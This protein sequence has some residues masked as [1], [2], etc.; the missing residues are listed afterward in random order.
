MADV[1]TSADKSRLDPSIDSIDWFGSEDDFFPPLPAKKDEVCTGDR[2][3]TRPTKDGDSRSGGVQNFDGPESEAVAQ[4][5][6]GQGSRKAGGGTDV[7]PQDGAAGGTDAVRPPDVVQKPALKDNPTFSGEQAAEALK[8]AKD[9]KLPVIVYM[10]ADWCPGCRQLKPQI[11]EKMAQMGGRAVLIAVNADKGIPAELRQTLEG[12]RTIPATWVGEATD[13][14]GFQGSKLGN[15][16]EVLT[17]MDKIK[18]TKPAPGPAKSETSPVEKE[19]EKEKDKVPAGGD[20]PVDPKAPEVFEGGDIKA[21]L[22]YAADN[23]LPI[24]VRESAGWCGPCRAMKPMWEK[25]Q[26]ELKGKAVFI[27][28][29]AD[30]YNQGQYGQEAM[31]LLQPIINGNDRIPAVWT[32]SA[33]LDAAGSPVADLKKLGNAWQ[34]TPMLDRLRSGR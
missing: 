13:G 33:S 14:G 24:F 9:N 10:G 5:R 34:V 21:A 2:C 20:K 3:E 23:K 1:D 18:A 11:E 17:R 31:Q 7:S 27:H 6:K 29:D 8:Y 4:Y 28:V 15:P 25:S 12:T 26:A 32:G 19:K 22:K 30:K 16:Y